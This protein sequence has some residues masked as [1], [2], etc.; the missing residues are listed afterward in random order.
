MQKHLIKQ[1]KY[2]VVAGLVVMTTGADMSEA[3]AAGIVSFDGSHVTSFE[4][5]PIHPPKA[6]AFGHQRIGHLG[7]SLL[8]TKRNKY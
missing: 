8:G 1:Q 4:L 2:D 6:A 5:N 7:F 3:S